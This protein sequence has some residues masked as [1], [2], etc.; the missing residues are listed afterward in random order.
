MKLKK[1]NLKIFIKKMNGLLFDGLLQEKLSFF[2]GKK[3]LIAFSGGKDSLAMLDFFNRNKSRYG[4]ELSACHVNHGIRKESGDDEEFCR[5]FC[6]DAEVDFCVRRLV[7]SKTKAYNGVEDWARR[8]RYKALEEV[9]AEKGCDYILTAH[10]FDDKLESF[11]TDLYTGASIFT[12][13]GISFLRGKICRP[14]LDIK[15]KDVE[16]YL[17][18]RGLTPIFDSSN[19]DTRF[20]R[21]KIRHTVLPALFAAG[22]EFVNTVL[23]LQDESWRLNGEFA[24]ITEETVLFN[25]HELVVLDLENFRK[26]SETAKHYLLGKLFSVRFRLSKALIDEALKLFDRVGSKRID[27]PD[28]FVFEVSVKS[29]R[30]FKKTLLDLFLVEKDKRTVTIDLLG[31]HVSFFGDYA[32]TLL[33]IR[34]RRKGDRFRGKKLKDLFIDSSFDTFFRDRAI[35]AENMTGEIVW[36]EGVSKS[37]EGIC[38]K[39]VF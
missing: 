15:T 3:L 31:V 27:L 25:M 39:R 23:N 6:K 18:H 36:V 2:K 29:V 16:N 1:L 10:T 8:G 11:F 22:D 28:G 4:F 38:V 34:N 37:C 12:I 32:E 35:I 14:M 17:L 7:F 24:K 21:N 13:G 19:D 5:L 9:L 30:I 20:V 33:L 26:L